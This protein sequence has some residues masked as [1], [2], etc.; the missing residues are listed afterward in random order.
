[1]SFLFN[2]AR[3]E[4]KAKYNDAA[5]ARRATFTPVI[6][7]CDGIFDHEAI[8]FMKRLSIFFFSNENKI[9]VKYTGGYWQEC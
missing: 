2:A 1:M 4:K 9:T 3:D 8:S 7:T 5:E 6:A